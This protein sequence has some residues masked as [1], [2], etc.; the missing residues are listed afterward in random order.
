MIV[1]TNVKISPCLFSS[2]LLIATDNVSFLTHTAV[3]LVP[4]GKAALHSV[5]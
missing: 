2:E 1:I 4:C 3:L 5:G